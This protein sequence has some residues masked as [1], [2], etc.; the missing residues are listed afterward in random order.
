MEVGTLT[1]TVEVSAE[2]ALIDVTQSKVQTN[3]PHD[4]PDGSAHPE[5]FVPERHS[6]CSGRALRT[7]AEQGGSANNGYQINGASNSENSYLVE[8]QETASIFDGHS[9]AN[10]PMDFIQE[11]QVKTSGFEAEY[12]G[13][14]GGVVNVI[15]QARLQR[16]AWQRVHVLQLPTGSTPLPTRRQIKNP[17]YAANSNG[18]PAGPA[19]RVL[20]AGQGPFADRRSGLHAGRRPD[21]G[22]S[23]GIPRR[24]A[25]LRPVG[26]HGEFHFSRG[27]PGPRRSTTTITPTIRWRAWISWQPR[28]SACMVPGMYSYAARHRHFFAAGATIVHGQF[29]ASSTHEPGQLQWRHRLRCAEGDLQHRRGYHH[30]SHA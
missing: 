27:A 29:N 22:S 5:P 1:E 24:R 7:A 13:A 28:R 9:Q 6:V 19:H 8:G 3:I 4:Q 26:A 12:G 23:V 10:V 15:S 16:M 17:Q 2:A 30:H 25:G 20:L 11:V 14:L 21:Q 18:A